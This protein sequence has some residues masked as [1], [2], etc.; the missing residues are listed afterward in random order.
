MNVKASFAFASRGSEAYFFAPR[1]SGHIFA[2]R[3]SEAALRHFF[4]FFF[5]FFLRHAARIAIN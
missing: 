3:G 2:S 1:G 4:F 5:F